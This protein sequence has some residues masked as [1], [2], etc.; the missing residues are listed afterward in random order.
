MWKRMDRRKAKKTIQNKKKAR[1]NYIRNRKM[2]IN[3]MNIYTENKRGRHRLRYFKRRSPTS[4]YLSLPKGL[5]FVPTKKDDLLDLKYGTLEFIRKF[6]WKAFFH[7]NSDSNLTVNLHQDIRISNF[8]QALFQHGIID[9][10]KTKLLGWIA[11]HKYSAAKHSISPLELRGRF[12]TIFITKANK[13]G[14]IL[15]IFKMHSRVKYTMRA[16]SRVSKPLQHI[17]TIRDKVKAT[18][19]NLISKRLHFPRGQI[20]NWTIR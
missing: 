14:A 19:I 10:R 11:N 4:A 16:S 12:K 13:G 1:E 18:T 7:Q 20:N 8:N 17:L 5:E 15:I 3:W 2:K 6:E 9:E